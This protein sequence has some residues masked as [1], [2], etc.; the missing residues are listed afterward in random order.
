[1][2]LVQKVAQNKLSS[3]SVKQ[4][5]DCDKLEDTDADNAPAPASI[6]ALA[7]LPTVPA[8]IKAV[9]QTRQ[10]ST[11][12]RAIRLPSA[13]FNPPTEPQLFRRLFCSLCY[14]NKP[15]LPN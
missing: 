11:A 15:L 14:A 2:L 7:P 6:L 10:T 1:M 5:P 12:P 13:P 9:P 4:E 3:F 8:P